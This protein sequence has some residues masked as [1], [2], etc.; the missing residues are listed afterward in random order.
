MSKD[1]TNVGSS[2]DDFLVEEG[3]YE[4]AHNC[5]IERVKNYQSGEALKQ[6]AELTNVDSSGTQGEP[7]ED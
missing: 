4:G 2:L 5:A 1:K 6:G 3:I 7:L